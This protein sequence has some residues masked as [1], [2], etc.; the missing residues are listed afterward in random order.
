MCGFPMG[1]PCH[2]PFSCSLLLSTDSAIIAWSPAHRNGV[3]TCWWDPVFEIRVPL[4]IKHG[5]RPLLLTT[6]GVE[7]P[8]PSTTMAAGE[9]ECCRRGNSRAPPL[10]TIWVVGEARRGMGKPMPPP[11]WRCDARSG[12]NHVPSF[13]RRRGSAVRWGWGL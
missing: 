5:P 1:P 7:A 12:R 13:R 11:I 10:G 9:E 2:R 8:S 4:T 6:S 3:R